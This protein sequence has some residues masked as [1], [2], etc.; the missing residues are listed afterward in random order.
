MKQ[1]GGSPV[2]PVER[3]RTM[4]RQRYQLSGQPAAPRD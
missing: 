2:S 1:D 4:M 3:F